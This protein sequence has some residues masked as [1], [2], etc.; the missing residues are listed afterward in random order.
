MKNG[1][2]KTSPGFP[3]KKVEE[4]RSFMLGTS[5]SKQLQAHN[6]NGIISVSRDQNGSSTG[7]KVHHTELFRCDSPE[8]IAEKVKRDKERAQ[9]LYWKAVETLSQTFSPE[10]YHKRKMSRKERKSFANYIDRWKP[11]GLFGFEDPTINVQHSL[12]DFDGSSIKNLLNSIFRYAP[13]IGVQ[14]NHKLDISPA[15]RKMTVDTVVLMKR[16][17]F[18]FLMLS[19]NSGKLYTSLRV[20]CSLYA[21]VYGDEVD[22]IIVSTTAALRLIL[23]RDAPQEVPDEMSELKAQ[24]DV[25][26]ESLSKEKDEFEVSVGCV[27]DSLAYIALLFATGKSFAKSSVSSFMKDVGGF[28]SFKNGMESIVASMFGFLEKVVDKVNNMGWFKP[29]K[30]VQSNNATVQSLI[31][32]VSVFHKRFSQ[33]PQYCWTTAGAIEALEKRVENTLSNTKNN[34]PIK[35]TLMR[36]LTKL[37]PISDKFASLNLSKI[38]TRLTPFCISFAGPSQIGK[39]TLKNVFLGEMLADTI[40]E[41]DLDRLEKSVDSFIYN[42]IPGRDFYDNYRGQSVFVIDDYGQFKEVPGQPGND[43][44]ELIRIV[45]NNEYLANMADLSDKGSCFIRPSLVAVTTNKVDIRADAL[46]SKEAVIRRFHLPFF[47]VPK[48]EY[49]M[50]KSGGNSDQALRNRQLDMSSIPQDIYSTDIYEFYLWDFDKGQKLPGA[51]LSYADALKMAIDKYKKHMKHGVGVL[52]S[53]TKHISAAIE[54]RRKT[55]GSFFGLVAQSGIP[56]QKFVET[57]MKATKFDRTFDVSKP[58]IYSVAEKHGCSQQQI[59]EEYIEFIEYV[60][61]NDHFVSQDDFEQFL[62][63]KTESKAW[64]EFL[65]CFESESSTLVWNFLYENKY[66]LAAII[67]TVPLGLILIRWLKTVL[68]PESGENRL[69][70]ARR[71]NR[72]VAKNATNMR[73]QMMVNQINAA[74]A[75]V[76]HNMFEIVDT[77]LGNKRVGVM[78]FVKGRYGLV[79]THVWTTMCNVQRAPGQYALRSCGAPD[80]LYP[81]DTSIYEYSSD[82][83]ENQ[84]CTKD[85]AMVLFPEEFIPARRNIMSW[86]SNDP[87]RYG[88]HGL[89]LPEGPVF[90]VPVVDVVPYS[91]QYTDDVA[92]QEL[93][94]YS[95]GTKQGDCGSP[96]IYADTG[97]TYNRINGIHVCGD[98]RSRGGSARVTLDDIQRL[99]SA[100]SGPMFDIE[101]QMDI[102]DAHNTVGG[103]VLPVCTVSKSPQVPSVS[104]IVR[105]RIHN[106]ITETKVMP[107]K[108][109]PFV[110]D[111][112]HKDPMFLASQKYSRPQPSVDIGVLRVIAGEAVRYILDKSTK[113]RPRVLTFEEAVAGDPSDQYLKGIPRSTSAGY[114]YNMNVKKRGKA[115]FFG[116]TGDYEFTSD[117]CLK[118]KNRVEEIRMLASQG[119]RAFHVCSDT[120][121]DETKSKE[122]VLAGKTRKF[123]PVPV[124]LLIITR[125]Y[126]GAL[127]SWLM[128]NRMSNMMCMGINPYTE[129]HQLGIEMRSF[130]KEMFDGDFACFDGTLPIS[131]MYMFLHL[132]QAYYYDASDEEQLIRSVLFE[133]VV[134]SRHLIGQVVYE[135]SGSNPSGGFLTTPLNS[136]CGIVISMYCAYQGMKNTCNANVFAKEFLNNVLIRNFGDDIIYS[137]KKEYLQCFNQKVMCETAHVLG[138]TFTPADKES[139]PIVSTNISG[140]SFLKRKFLYQ[141]G[142]FCGALEL[143]SIFESMNWVKKGLTSQ[144]FKQIVDNNILELSLHG[145]QVYEEWAPLIA[146]IVSSRY[147]FTPYVPKFDVALITISGQEAYWC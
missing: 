19:E 28:P 92:E 132:A 15:A 101:P 56:N 18:I 107:C 57:C 87:V 91:G 135:F 143:D 69:V 127:V 20:I 100:L 1:A 80:I 50:N 104:K 55:K 21:F 65:S 128:H 61:K 94:F 144:Q 54:R 46:E 26:M 27:A 98:S 5:N 76:M 110:V 146:T 16:L 73:P 126:F 6:N 7:P 125:Q 123:A 115:D 131:V 140:I 81:M 89:V 118:L 141:N 62:L 121:K 138:M 63:K 4:N 90:S 58:Y 133:D 147:D 83:D 111:G 77:T 109:R 64:S 14:V 137:V 34:D 93:L 70:S 47:V 145:K 30:L 119:I 33:N 139:Q 99:M 85:V 60:A 42:V 78:T 75:L 120:L 86:F 67:G 2:G 134:N 48:A 129:W 52:A 40:E 117:E 17:V 106:L 59:E 25:L 96:L 66:L 31:D 12:A 49:C 36:A 112:E 23:Y 43:S 124:D 68:Q 108:L 39:S 9:K 130:S 72:P 44:M 29:V 95:L 22:K 88:K 51:A 71:P 114:P 102:T 97:S 38:G 35:S 122:K 32:E 105:S 24:T 41:S 74:K 3:P 113:P 79:P 136:F 37:K 82:W 10:S 8:L 11:Q 45:N 103:H 116:S 13:T 84:I 142:Q 53:Q